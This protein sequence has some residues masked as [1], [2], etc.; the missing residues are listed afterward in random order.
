MSKVSSMRGFT[1]IELMI[2]VAIIGILA[3]IAYPS[4]T[5]QVRKTRRA[6]AAGALVGL[7]AVLERQYTVNGSY[8]DSGGTGGANSCGAAG[9]ND[10][11][12]PATALYSSTSP[13]DGGTAAYNLTINAATA[14]TFTLHA[15]PTGPQTGDK[16]GTFTLTQAGVKNI[17]GQSTGIVSDDCWY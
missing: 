13:V 7:A 3:A 10:T 14:T 11:G 5:E 1:L 17:T 6:D 15:A 9:T 8:C 4:Y 16:C 12:S 2:V